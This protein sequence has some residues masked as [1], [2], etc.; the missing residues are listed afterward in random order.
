M[1]KRIAIMLITAA[2]MTGFSL[3][4]QAELF[5]VGPSDLPSPTGHGYPRWYQ[6]ARNREP[7]HQP[8]VRWHRTSFARLFLF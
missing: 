5:R 3:L 4:S 2:W 7:D 6:P 8:W 1:F